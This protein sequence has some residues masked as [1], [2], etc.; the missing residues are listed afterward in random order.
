MSLQD[1]SAKWVSFCCIGKV[2]LFTGHLRRLHIHV[3]FA[4]VLRQEDLWA[5]HLSPRI[6]TCQ[7]CGHLTLTHCSDF[8]PPIYHTIV[9][10]ICDKIFVIGT[11]FKEIMYCYGDSK[12]WTATVFPSTQH[13]E[14]FRLPKLRLSRC[15]K[16]LRGSGDSPDSVERVHW[17][18]GDVWGTEQF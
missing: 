5:I 16:L 8:T 6:R 13:L 14:F 17:R 4:I 15:A 18:F 1:V 12:T 10:N 11:T 7:C 9:V 2:R 3:V